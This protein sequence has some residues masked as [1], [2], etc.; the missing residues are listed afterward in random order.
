MKK[1]IGE[2]LVE[3]ITEKV[4]DEIEKEGKSQIDDIINQHKLST[5][6]NKLYE[7]LLKKYGN[8]PFYNELCNI[9]LNN[10]NL[11]IFIKRS[12]NRELLD[13]ETDIELIERI[14]QGKS[15][16]IYNRSEVKKCLIDI[17]KITY[18]AFNE[19]KDPENI[20]L[21]NIMFYEGDRINE[22]IEQTQEEILKEIKELNQVR[23]FNGNDITRGCKNVVKHFL[24]REDD[25]NSILQILNLDFKDNQKSSIW[26]YGMGGMGKTQLCRKLYSIVQQQYPYVGW[27]TNIGNFKES[28]VNSINIHKDTVDLEKEYLEI[29]KFLNSLGKQLI[30]FIDNY[31][32]YENYLED[33]ERLQCNVIITSRNKS[34]DTFTGY[35]LGFLSFSNCKKLFRYFYTLE[36]NMIMNEIIHKTGY[37]ALAVELVAKTG[38]KMALPLKEYYEK[39]VEKGFDIKTIIQ[40]NWDNNGDNLN[41]EL[42]KH[43]GIVFDLASLKENAEAIY[44]LKNFSVLPYLGV[45]QQEI[46][47][48]LTLDSEQN[49]LIDLVDLGW[50]QKIEQ[51]YMMHPIIS[52]TVKS[53]LSPII[54]DCYNLIVSLSKKIKNMPG[55]N[56]LKAFI[57]LPYADSVGSYF[58]KKKETKELR[59][60]A[61]LYIRIAEIYRS[62]GEYNRAYTWGTE[63]CK[64]LDNSAE[65]N[66]S[67]G[68][69]EN[70]I[71]NIMSEICLDMR[72][73][74]ENCRDWA[75][76]ATISDAHSYDVDDVM[77]STSFH[78]LACAFIQLNEFEK[79]LE[80]ELIAV[81]LRESSLSKSDIRLMNSYRNLAMIYRRLRDVEKAYYY[82]KIVVEKLE[83]IY[84][85]E[86]NHPDF[87]V[88][89]N[90]YSF[91]LRDLGQ[92]EKAIE[93]Q[94]KAV[95]IR[96]YINEND[97]KLAINYNN[98]GIFNLE[99]NNLKEAERWQKKSIQMDIKHR[100][101]KHPDVATD[102]FNYAKILV[103][104]GN[105]K[106]AVKYLEMSREIEMIGKENLNNIKEIDDMLS[107]IQNSDL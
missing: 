21:K 107:D 102:Y 47:D 34:P 4:K 57:Y 72:D 59:L 100:G 99:R 40:S 76:K 62:N 55:D 70:L 73:N 105:I 27:I 58:I 51:E 31:D 64:V 10:N 38:Q 35:K 16:T 18:K 82:Q 23:T 19:L 101:P 9:L 28:L 39:L 97:P 93:Y 56:Y 90:I 88:V 77:K 79:A 60:L 74:N 89:Y 45:T 71:Y 20:I 14:L 91:I 84:A 104:I 85:E 103:A 13:D 49:Y 24:G 29:L 41:V 3:K 44:I 33:I 1:N 8:E 78:N 17:S 22:K 81:S 95:Q 11:D 50:I 54:Q 80:N 32:V 75:L 66:V 26:I 7:E 48:W 92:L 43:F 67:I 52:Y 15:I 65:K 2:I 98:L 37:L 6:K 46:V 86:K 5:Y 12:K 68:F 61:V 94:E 96:E 36:D 25:I 53:T 63:A 106:D 30:V 42:S 83:L 87:P 69:L